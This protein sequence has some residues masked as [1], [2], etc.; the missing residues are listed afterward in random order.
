MLKKIFLS[1]L[2]GIIGTIFFAQYDQW[3][4]QKIVQLLQ[5][6]A[7][8]QL[9][10]NLSATV[11]AV[12]F[13]TPSITLTDLQMSSVDAHDWQWRCKKFEMTCSWLQLIFKGILDQHAVVE[14]Y[15]CKTAFTTSG[16]AIE[17]HINA[18]MQQSFVPFETELKSVVF[19][20][21]CLRVDHDNGDNELFI[22]FNSSSLRIGKQFK[23]TMSIADGHVIGQRVQYIEKMAMDVSVVSEYIN[24]RFDVGVYVAGSCVL[25]QMEHQGNCYVTGSW[26]SDCGRFSVRNAYNTLT[27]DPIVITERE[28]RMNARFPVSYA[29]QCVANSLAEYGIEGVAHCGIRVSR[30]EASKVEGQL[31]VEDVR[32]GKHHVCDVGKMI[33]E[34]QH[35]HDEWKMRFMVNRYNQEC[36]GTGHWYQNTDMGELTIKNNTDMSAKAFP[37]WRISR[38]NFFAQITADKGIIKSAYEVTTTNTL[39]NVSHH[40]TGSVAYEHGRCAALGTI[41]GYTF[42]T[43][44]TIYPQVV[45]HH[46]WCKDKDDKELVTLQNPQDEQHIT[47]T[48]AFPFIR[49]M[50]NTVMHYDVQ[51]EGSLD[52]TARYGPNE[53]VADLALHDATIRL[54]QTYNFIDGFNARCT[55]N[56][57]DRSL[58]FENNTF[59]LHTGKVHCLRATLYFNE[60]GVLTCMHAPLIA[61]RCLLTIKKDLFAL[62]SGNLLFSK[63]SSLPACV[64]GHVI[65]DKAQLKEN[66]F[67]DVIQKQLLSY[68]HTAFSL[69]DVPLFCDLTLETKSPIRLDT[70]FFKANAQVHLHVVKEKH[71]P[72]VTG[73]VI[74]HSGTLNFPYKPLY[75][76]K[77]VITFIPEQL[78]DPNIELVAR[79]KIKKYDVT[80]QV[81]GSLSTHH[82]ML[83]ATPPLTEEQIVGL[84]LVGSEENSLNSMMPA[85]IVQNLKS[86]IFSN[87]QS[88]FFD[89]Y[90]KPLLGTL[91]INLVPSFIDQT[92]RGGLRGALEITVDDR[93]RALIQKNFSLTEDTKFELE[94]LFS[95]DITL[96]AVR[97]ERRDLGG[98]VEMRWKF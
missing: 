61:D 51:G 74:L 17:P 76:S 98:E 32:I 19:K 53:V 24:N 22:N 46:C 73:A 77:G 36:A 20:N 58:T 79:N 9:K 78:F 81:E 41:D 25:P 90:F 97:D 57:S 56:V 95:D 39:N 43:A 91:N 68:T 14:G 5:K 64:S 54:P 42:D 40:S 12:S 11:Q 28:I 35:H 13:F 47:G 62:V 71:D 94:F 88:S 8:E 96:R 82:I 59:S 50:I 72:C 75:I 52:V 66:L 69:P 84:L 44:A 29:A 70:G 60:Y 26:K 31:I 3:T 45:L 67:S 6:I 7:R 15:E 86:L 83:D 93:W 38:N 37:H 2:I 80:L 65:I 30:D 10:G 55:Y 18:M 48:I 85:L 1:V 92:G 23:T 4:H 89:K 33:F 16:L 49:S 34:R 87:N 63:V 21:G 27:L